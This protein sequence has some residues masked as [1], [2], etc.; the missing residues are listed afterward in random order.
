MLQHCIVRTLHVAGGE[1]FTFGL[2]P[3]IICWNSLSA[4]IKDA[5]FNVILN[6]YLLDGTRWI[7]FSFIGLYLPQYL[8]GPLSNPWHVCPNTSFSCMTCSLSRFYVKCELDCFN[9]KTEVFLRLFTSMFT[10]ESNYNPQFC[11]NKSTRQWGIFN[12]YEEKLSVPRVHT[13]VLTES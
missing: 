6:D 4:A 1:N 13:A 11:K 9:C 10:K 7:L 3:H 8:S 2:R 12:N 5:I